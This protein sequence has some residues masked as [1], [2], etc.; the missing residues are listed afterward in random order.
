MPKAVIG[1]DLEMHYL[2]DDF[3]DPW[4]A[5]ETILML[6]GNTE[7][8]AAWYGWVPHLARHFR[9][10]RP[11]TRGYGASTVMPLDYPWSLDRIVDDFIVLMQTL[12]IPRF[13]LIG[14]KIGG[15]FARHLAARFPKRVLT[16]TVVGA[17]PAHYEAGPRLQSQRKEIEK[18]GIEGW[19]RR[20]MAGRLGKEFPAAGIDWFVKLMGQTAVSSTLGFISTVPA[21]DITADLPLI[22]CPTLVITSAGSGYGSVDATR[23][24]QEKIV[25]SKLVVLPGDSFHVAASNPDGC[26]LETLHFI[27]SVSAGDGHSCDRHCTEAAPFRLYPD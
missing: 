6:H 22:K 9:V 12:A 26:A 11:D 14:A 8:S 21:T 5:P 15:T 13:H 17:P 3:T 23:A 24:W 7:S 27:Q 4:T 18:E 19:A 25:H 2:I 20:T 10:V 16:L 1:P